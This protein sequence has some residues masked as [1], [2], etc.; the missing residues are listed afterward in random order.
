MKQK[1]KEIFNIKRISLL[2]IPEGPL[3]KAVTL[4][5]SVIKILLLLL[6]Y[7]AVIAFGSF[8]FLSFTPFGELLLPKKSLTS[9]DMILI[10]ELNEKIIFLTTE[11]SSL[12]TSNERLKNAILK[13]DSS[14]ADTLPV[15]NR[16][17]RNK[18]GGNLLAV[19]KYLF[20]AQDEKIGSRED[21]VFFIQPAASFI[22]RH[23]NPEKGHMGI[24][25]VLT[26]GT[27]VYASASGYVIFADYTI[28]SGYMMIINHPQNYLTIYKHC[29]SLIKKER[30]VVNQGELIALSGNSG[31]I[32]TGP[33]LHFEIWKDGKP[34][35]PE[36][37]IIN[38]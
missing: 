32:S 16:I 28:E 34:V 22:S 6:L 37:F 31:K 27:P 10:E 26:S 11:L 7:T 33:H 38:N 4:K 2:I 13:G 29:S 12:K 20:F 3:R 30:E 15:Q 8:Y 19:I 17:K 24:D 21:P 14:L 23:F 5:L 35:N 25:Y 1:L 36:D 18:T 9:E